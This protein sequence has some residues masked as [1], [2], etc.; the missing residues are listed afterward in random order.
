MISVNSLLKSASKI[1]SLPIVKVLSEAANQAPKSQEIEG[2]LSAQ[3]LAR[4]AATDIAAML[5][6]GWSETYTA[7]MINTWL[8]DNGVESF[9]HKAFVWFGERSRFDGVRSYYDYLPGK[10][11]LR[12]NEVFVLDVAPIVDGYICD[13][14]YSNCFGTDPEFEKARGYLADLRQAIPNMFQALSTGSEIWNAIDENIR[15][16]DFEN[17]HKKYPFSVLGHRIH[18]SRLQGIKANLINFGWQSYW[19]LLSRGL[20][21]QLLNQNFEGDLTGLWAIEPHIG[22]ATFGAKFEEI[23]VVDETGCRWIEEDGIGLLSS[24]MTSFAEKP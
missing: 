6:P 2:F 4:Q 15:R 20:F 22:T 3:R 21:G 12:E 13:I 24:P 10:R 1:T 5:Q 9:F 14:G 23:L 11:V 7:D 19:E 16:N 17:I 8:R 18:R